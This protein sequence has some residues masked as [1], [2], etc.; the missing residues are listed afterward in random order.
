MSVLISDSFKI[1]ES[2]SDEW[3]NIQFSINSPGVPAGGMTGQVLK[4]ASATDYDTVW[5]DNIAAPATATPLMDG[6]AAVGLSAKYAREDHVHP[7]DTVL[8]AAVEAITQQTA[9]ITIDYT[10]W[11]GSG[12]YTQVVTITGATITANT[13][14]D[15]QPDAAALQQLID[16]EVTAL[17]VDNT[18]GTLTVYAVGAATT[19]DITVQVTYYETI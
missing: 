17:F 15:L 13:K 10:A 6:T 9:T 18:N 3:E 1:R 5:T 4:K 2:T 8:A 12:P 16:D 11:S 19:A 14:V 7:R